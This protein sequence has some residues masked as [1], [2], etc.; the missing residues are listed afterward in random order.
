MTQRYVEG[1]DICQ[2]VKP[3][4]HAP[5]GLLAQ[6]PVPDKK[7]T[8]ITYDFITGLPQCNK[9]DAL[10]VIVDRFSKGA[11]FIPCNQDESAE[12]MAQL[13]LDN[14]WKLHGTPTQTVSDRGT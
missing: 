4:R 12:S 8:H 1:C 2:Q 7:W 14:I 5:Y 13:F 11:Y 3:A 10:L 6:L 9:K